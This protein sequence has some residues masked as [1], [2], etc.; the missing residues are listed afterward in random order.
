MCRCHETRDGTVGSRVCLLRCYRF[1][2]GSVCC[3]YSPK[4]HGSRL[5]NELSVNTC[6]FFTVAVSNHLSCVSLQVTVG[7][8]DR[9]GRLGDYKMADREEDT[10][11]VL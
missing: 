2:S 9:L 4:E 3:A 10:A 11:Q 1:F 7:I 8:L 6:F 5:L